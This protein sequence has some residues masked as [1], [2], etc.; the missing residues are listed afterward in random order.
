MHTGLHQSCV[1]HES[2][3]G[4]LKLLQLLLLM[5]LCYQ[6]IVPRLSELAKLGLTFFLAFGPLILITV[7]LFG[8]LFAVSLS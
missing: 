7:A 3:E 1:A 8:G 5:C 4:V 6:G 2:F